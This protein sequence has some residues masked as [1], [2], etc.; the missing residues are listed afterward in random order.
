MRVH[1]T[2]AV[3]YVLRETP[4]TRREHLG[5]TTAAPL[6][7]DGPLGAATKLVWTD[8]AEVPYVPRKKIVVV[9]DDPELRDLETFLFGAEGYDVVGVP[10]GIEAAAIV[11]RERA[12]LVLL[13]L[14]LPGKDGN[15]VL[16]ELADD[17]DTRRTPVIVVSAFLAQLR[18]TPQVCLVLSKPF[19]VSDLLDAVARET[20][21]P[22]EEV[23]R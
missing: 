7:T 19:D 3:P 15:T 18:L 22:R 16:A 14:M 23:N 17:P 1:P 8:R 12:D 9:E 10:D 2:G 6:A 20:E 5:E 11:K 4:M 21:K 13:D